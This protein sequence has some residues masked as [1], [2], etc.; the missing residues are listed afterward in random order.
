MYPKC[1]RSERAVNLDLHGKT[2][3]V[4]GGSGGI[5]SHVCQVLAEEGVA[6]AVGY[7]K[8]ADGAGRVVEDIRSTGE[9][10][11]A[12]QFDVRD[13]A[14]VR[15]AV[16]GVLREFGQLDLLV[17]CAGVAY[18]APL[19]DHDTAS[20]QDVVATNLDGTF[21]CCRAV[22]PH[23]VQR[24]V[25][26]IVNV[27]SLAGRIGSFEGP[28]YAASKAGVDLLTRSLALE[29][30][31]SN[32]RVNGV[33]PGRIQTS[34]RRVTSGPYFDFMIQQTPQGRLGAAREVANVVVFLASRAGAFITGE[35]L[36][37]TGGLH[38]VY[39]SHVDADVRHLGRQT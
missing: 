9:R 10:A 22:T 7:H 6:V 30:A 2:A 15:D 39:L 37:M 4:T 20:W 38:T 16:D 32:I 23:F 3:L 14:Q 12:F 24:G 11:R 19:M 1:R 36:Y 8:N 26:D 35:T 29:L 18:F 5:G 28:A 13:P 25:G 34:F 21:Y 33:A 27:S 17:N 31:A